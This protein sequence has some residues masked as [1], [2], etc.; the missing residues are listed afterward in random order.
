M[1]H[2]SMF[3]G[4]SGIILFKDLFTGA[5]L[6]L[7]KW[8]KDISSGQGITFSI[9]SNEAQ[10]A[11]A[12]TAGTIQKVIDN[13]ITT[14]NSWDNDYLVSIAKHDWTNLNTLNAQGEHGFYIDDT[15]RIYYGNNS[16]DGI[17]IRIKA[18]DVNVFD[19]D[20]IMAA[21]T[22]YVK[23]I[24]DRGNDLAHFYWW[25]DNGWGILAENIDTS[26]FAFPATDPKLG[27]GVGGESN[28]RTGGD[29][30]NMDDVYL[31]SE[32]IATR[33]PGGLAAVTNNFNSLLLNGTDQFVNIDTINTA[34]A[35]TTTGTWMGYYKP[36]DATPTSIEKIIAFGDTDAV[37]FIFLDLQ[38]NGKIR[39]F[40]ND[41]GAQKWN[42]TTNISPLT[43]NT[44]CHLAIVFDG[45]DQTFYYNGIELAI[46]YSVDTTKAYYF[47]DFYT[48]DHGRMGC[49]NQNSGGDSAF[50]AANFKSWT[51]TSDAKTKLEVIDACNKGIPKDESAISNGVAYIDFGDNAGDNYNDDVTDAWLFTGGIGGID[52]QTGTTSVLASVETDVPS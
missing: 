27:F 2:S 37:G 42:F 34:L 28:T 49:L 20:T 52:V 44:W 7:S 26:S 47:N 3:I 38:T 1:F 16:T 32:D 48:L 17:F 14:V 35:S 41:G 24:W 40:C 25:K 45:V 4:T 6:D 23:I 13:N 5:S 50:N 36:A 11:A 31:L 30:F 33:T 43:D 19:D 8:V 29:T 22:A 39:G 10:F 51:F 21:Y 9:A 18:D 12:H 15:N 46:T